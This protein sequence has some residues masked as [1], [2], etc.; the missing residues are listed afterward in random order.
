[1]YKDLRVGVIVAAAGQG[2][3]VGGN[4]KKQY[5]LIGDKPVLAHTLM[6]VSSSNLVDEIVVVVGESEIEYCRKNIIAAYKIDK[7]SCVVK[8][9]GERQ[10]SVFEGLLSLKGKCGIVAVHDGARPFVTAGMLDESIRKAYEYDAAACAVS[11]K[12]TIKVVDKNR[13]IVD[14][15]D[16]S[17][18]Y[19]VQTPQTFKF[20]LIF[21]AHIKALREGYTGTD[22]TVLVERMGTRV[23]IFN[24]SYENIKITTP[25]DLYIAEA[26]NKYRIEK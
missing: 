11:V 18:L 17:Q 2:S 16:R 8:G 5:L 24:G 20:D 1:M 7:I 25:E 10:Q 13:W 3:R 12:D 6:A 14:T 19:A 4:I 9:G 22:D 15:P 23:K 26:M 21:R